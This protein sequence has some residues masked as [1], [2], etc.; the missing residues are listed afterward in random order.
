[1]EHLAVA[2]YPEHCD[3]ARWPQ[4]LARMKAHGIDTV[5]V[6]EFAWSRL[7]RGENVWTFDWLH[8][9]MQLTEREGICV[10]PCTPSAAPPAWLTQAH[11]E[12]L[13]MNAQGVRS[14]HGGR[15]HYCPSS[16]R[17]RAACVRVV[18]EM[19]KALAGYRNVMAWQIDNELGF[20]RCFCPECDR[21]F[22]RR[23]QAQYGT[24]EKLNAAWGGAFWSVDYWDWEHVVVPREGNAAISPEMHVAFCQFY[25]DTIISFMDEQYAALRA[26]GCQVPISTNM[27]GNFD[28]IDYW[29]MAKHVDFIGWDNYWFLTTLSSHSF[30]HHLMRGLRGGQP[31]WTFE[32]GVEMYPGFNVVHGLSGQAHG[33]IVHTI[34]RWDSCPFGHEMDLVGLVDHAGEP[35]AKLAEMKELYAA[36]QQVKACGLPPLRPRVAVLFSYQNYWA[37]DRYFGTYWNEVND[38]Y[39]A[40]FD[41]G[42]AC[43]CVP[44]GGD[45][46]PYAL[47]LAPGLG[48][49]SDAELATIRTYVQAG[50]VLVA[51]RKCFSKTP[52]GSYRRTVHPALTDVFGLRV[53]ESMTD[54]DT[55]EITASIYKP[56]F[57][58][59]SF[60]LVAGGAGLPATRTRGWFEVLEPFSAQTIYRYEDGDFSGRAAA[61]VNS[62]G[63][64]CAFYLGSML[65]RAAMKAVL[66]QAAERAGLGSLLVEVPQGVEL[67]RRGD[68][69]IV[70]NFTRDPIDVAIPGAVQGLCGAALDAGRA[71]VTLPPLGYS[72]VRCG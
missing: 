8:R 5:R 13:Q 56:P 20:N 12:C 18:G 27:M 37:M 29:E 14:G 1:M 46:T 16:A 48:L 35:R 28:Q 24:L 30:T 33:E 68:R 17:Y 10:V 4:D 44:P 65:E 32:N 19:Q 62:F 69:C 34:F 42:L 40:L 52:S 50:G 64:G 61:C 36:L 39:Q 70:L 72:V 3:E 22:R 43:D 15:R 51:G 49:V 47:V 26:A 6:F 11:P 2:Y 59:R 55:V 71:A 60:N 57:P 9:F 23:L 7:Q 63:R 58:R 53:V 45:L 21:E 54:E 31:Y 25:S 67:V 66:R 41:L 38:F